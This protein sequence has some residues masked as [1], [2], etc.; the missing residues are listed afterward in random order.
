LIDRAKF[1]PWF[2]DGIFE[3]PHGTK[4]SVLRLVAQVLESYSSAGSPKLVC[5][6]ENSDGERIQTMA[7]RLLRSAP[8]FCWEEVEYLK[9][10]LMVELDRVSSVLVV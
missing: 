2:W 4:S 6:Y 3:S 5:L 8:L 1:N 10:G 7:P 9:F